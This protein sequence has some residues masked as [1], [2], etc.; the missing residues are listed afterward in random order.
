MVFTQKYTI[1]SPI[2]Q[3]AEGQV[4]ESIDW[5]LHTTVADTFAVNAIDDDLISQIQRLVRGRTLTVL[6]GESAYFGKNADIEVMLLQAS[7]ELHTLHSNLVDLLLSRGA[8]FN[9]PQYT[10][11]GFIGHVTQQATKRLAVNEQVRLDAV[12]IID[13][14]PRENP[15]KRRVIKIIHFQER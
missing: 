9:D 10:K 2:E 15:N 12:A 5:P 6:G 13:M 11:A 3:V 7:P 14:F 1:I 8:I 4:F